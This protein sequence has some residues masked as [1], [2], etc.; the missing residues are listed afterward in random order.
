[1]RWIAGTR[2]VLALIVGALSMLLIAPT[3]G[4]AASGREPVIV[5][6]GLGGSEFVATTAFSLNVD[7]GHGGTFNRSYSAGEKVWV[8]PFQILLPGDDYYLDALKLRSDGTTPVAPAVQVSGLYW[9][10]YGD[11]ADYL[12]RQGY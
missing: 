12:Q 3:T 10:A 6:P 4:R 9:D 7:N 5:I 11:L 1:M 8:N 2:A